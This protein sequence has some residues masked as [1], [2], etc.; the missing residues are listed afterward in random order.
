MVLKGGQGG[1]YS[2]LENVHTYTIGAEMMKYQSSC[3]LFEIPYTMFM[4]G[5]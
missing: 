3:S 1:C 2:R 5:T 4:Q